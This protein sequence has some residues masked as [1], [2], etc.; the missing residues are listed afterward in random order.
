MKPNGSFLPWLC[1]LLCLLLVL[2][3][4]FAASGCGKLPDPVIESGSDSAVRPQTDA[5]A[6]TTEAQI[7]SVVSE[8]EPSASTETEPSVPSEPLCMEEAIQRYEAY[9]LDYSPVE[10]EAERP[11]SSLPAPRFSLGP[12][13]IW[14]SAESG[15]GPA[16][17][18][19][20]GDLL[21]QTRQQDKE[22]RCNGCKYNKYYYSD[23]Q[24]S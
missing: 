5:P 7:S 13:G 20:T 14:R 17:L 8:P 21:C 16:V 15:D 4:L 3:L 24:S 22:Y 9:P 11:I 23:Y 19:L 1:R 2:I 12:D 6:L 18:M 10:R